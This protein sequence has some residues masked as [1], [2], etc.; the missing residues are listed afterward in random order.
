MSNYIQDVSSL[1]KISEFLSTCAEK[2]SLDKSKAYKASR[3]RS[4][5]DNKI[6]DLITD[7]K[8]MIF[9]DEIKEQKT[10][11]QVE[12]ELK[13]LIDQHESDHKVFL[14]HSD[15]GYVKVC[16]LPSTAKDESG[17][18]AEASSV[19]PTKKPRAGFRKVKE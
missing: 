7:D 12:A 19:T 13:T 6:V 8:F 1:I 2:D 10:M 17:K 4:V 11:A 15:P 16:E 14:N 18:T 5:V 3:L 9:I